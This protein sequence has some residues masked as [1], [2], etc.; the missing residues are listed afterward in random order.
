MTDSELLDLIPFF[1]K[2]SNVDNIYTM[3]CNSNHPYNKVPTSGK[4]NHSPG[5][6]S[7]GNS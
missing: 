7:L 3:L 2:L 1:E 4:N 5:S 6:G